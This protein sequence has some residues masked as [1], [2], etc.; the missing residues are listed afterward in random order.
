MIANLLIRHEPQYRRAS[1]ER[2]LRACGYQ[3][4]GNPRGQPAPDDVLVIWNRYAYYNACAEQ[5]E[6]VGA[7]VI[8]AENGPLGRDW[9]GE[10]WYAITETNPLAGGTWPD[11][12]AERWD[13]MNVMIRQWRT[14]GPEILILAQ[15][16][17]GPNGVR[18]PDGW[19]R[20]AYD[21]LAALGLNVRIREHPGERPQPIPLEQDLER[22]ARVVTWASGA[23]FKALLMGVPVFYGYDKWVGRDAALPL[24][25]LLQH[26]ATPMQW[27]DRLPT[28]RRLAWSMWRTHEIET[29]LPFR[30]LL[31]SESSG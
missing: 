12:P 14:G 8:V 3:I 19:H 16:G 31:G 7:R 23:A 9:R 21:E 17:I 11:G 27:P 24:S 22:A 25:S 13:S 30:R 20:W 28:F 18:Q 6:R 5:F 2:G 29:G 15:R 4:G 26:P 1:F 10:P